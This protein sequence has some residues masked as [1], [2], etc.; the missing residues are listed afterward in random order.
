MTRRLL[1]LSALAATVACGDPAA[2]P[3]DSVYLAVHVQ[4]P[5]L[6]VDEPTTVVV[7]VVN[8]GRTPAVVYGDGCPAWY[9]VLAGAVPVAPGAELCAL[10]ATRTTLAPGESVVRTYTWAG[11]TMTA[12]GGPGVPLAPGSYVLEARV[13]VGGKILRSTGAAVRILP[14]STSSGATP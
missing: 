2:G 6:V 12:V 1:A 7:S 9:T 13:P 11:R 5:E 3:S 10:A 8:L 4:R 14:G